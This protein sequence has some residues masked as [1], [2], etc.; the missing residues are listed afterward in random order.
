MALFGDGRLAGQ[1]ALV[2]GASSGVGL[3]TARL[4]VAEGGRVALVARRG[5]RLAEIVAELGGAAI[6]LSA[7]IADDRAV[8]AAVAEAWERLGGLDIAV[9]AAGIDGP[10]HLA[11]LTPEIWRRQLD[12]NLSGTFYVA[13]EVALRMQAGAGGVI[14]NLGSE[15]SLVG[16]GLYA[17][18]CASK[19]GV[20]GLTKALAHELAPKVRVNCLCPGPI[21]T[22]MMDAE[23]EWFPDPAAT[24]AAAIDRV[25]LKRFATAEEVARAVLF[26]AVDAPFA[27]GSVFSL[28]GGTTAI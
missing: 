20:V 28:D 12:V 18:Y 1:R 23:L 19:F 6:A 13:R 10:S 25:P 4:F 24:R 22:P 5:D 8:A 26:L 2:T 17:H 3:A 21:D 9:N 16:M 11:D 7:D 27:T 14:V 15:L